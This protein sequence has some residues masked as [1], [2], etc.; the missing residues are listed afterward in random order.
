MEENSATF[1]LLH[2]HLTCHLLPLSHNHHVTHTHTQ[3]QFSVL[4][5]DLIHQHTL[6]S[7]YHTCAWQCSRATVLR[8]PA[9]DTGRINLGK[10]LENCTLLSS[11]QSL[12]SPIML[13][14]LSGK[15]SPLTC[16]SF[17]SPALSHSLHLPWNSPVF[18]PANPQRATFF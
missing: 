2:L 15:L 11:L 13:S 10:Q 14:S 5:L 12:F 16:T 4:Y 9:G 8:Y 3:L 1:I 6:S 18:V 7:T 17:R